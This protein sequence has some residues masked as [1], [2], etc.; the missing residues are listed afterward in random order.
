[1]NAVRTLITKM[2]FKSDRRGINNYNSSVERLKA[3]MDSLKY[4]AMAFGAAMTGVGIFSLKAAGEMEQFKI[5]FDTMLGSAEAGSKMMK[6]LRELTLKTPFSF[7][8]SALGAKRLMAFGISAEKVIPALKNIG[9]IAS[10]VGMHKLK[11]IITA[12]GQI[13]TARFL[14]GQE[15]RQLTES[16][17]PII[18]ELAD[19]LGKTPDQITKMSRAS[20][21]LFKH[22]EKAIHRLSNGTGRFTN[23]TGRQSKKLL[24]M[25]SIAK[26]ALYL[27]A[28]DF[29]SK[30][31]PTI[32]DLVARLGGVKEVVERIVTGFKWIISSTLVLGLLK[33]TKILY[34]IGFAGLASWLKIFLPALLIAGVVTVL[35]GL[36]QSLWVTITDPDADTYL[37][38]M[39]AT[40][41][42]K[43]PEAM[44]WLEQKWENI[45]EIIQDISD[46]IAK[47]DFKYDITGKIKKAA[48]KMSKFTPIGLATLALEWSGIVDPSTF[49]NQPKTDNGSQSL[50]IEN[51][52]FYND[53]MTPN[54]GDAYSQ[55]YNMGEGVSDALQKRNQ[56]QSFNEEILMRKQ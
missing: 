46:L 43:Y 28:S 24:G 35:V 11:E 31:I 53:Y 9:N 16:G 2:L 34:G 22:V 18:E 26:D 21:I 55:G 40:L 1:M 20:L 33:L 25:F 12:Y 23:L 52:N 38:R 36:F 45:K 14:R 50:V 56:K 7:Q 29:G 30:F 8:Q 42:Y 15:I 48:W 4:K 41:A 3:N 5:A 32:E 51:M 47:L 49:V 10:G 37:R 6:D 44:E 17:I 27:M 54:D 13:K 39:Y 19:M